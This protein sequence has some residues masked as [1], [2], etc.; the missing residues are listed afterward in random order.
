MM[1][2]QINLLKL[3]HFISA[4]S[5]I[6]TSVTSKLHCY[7]SKDFQNKQWIP[8]PG[9]SLLGHTSCLLQSFKLEKKVHK[10]REDVCTCWMSWW[11]RSLT[12]HWHFFCASYRHLHGNSFC[13]YCTTIYK[14]WGM[15]RCFQ[16]ACQPFNL[17]L[18]VLLLAKQTAVNCSPQNG[19]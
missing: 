14:K 19:L 9:F 13:F 17:R 3:R 7:T 16:I 4:E 6:M 12:N 10:R 18:L 5:E 15:A 8:I 11:E 1:I 2:W